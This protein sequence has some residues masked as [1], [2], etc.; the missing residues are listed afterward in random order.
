MIFTVSSENTGQHKN[1]KVRPVNK[2][3]IQPLSFIVKN[4]DYDTGCSREGRGRDDEAKKKK[5]GRK[6]ISLN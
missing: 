1:Y 5:P 4:I 2:N 3:A 6:L